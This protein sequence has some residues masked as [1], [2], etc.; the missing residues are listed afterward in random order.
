MKV[1]PTPSDL[2]HYREMEPR[3]DGRLIILAMDQKGKL[4]K[5]KND[6]LIITP[7]EFGMDGELKLVTQGQEIWKLKPTR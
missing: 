2:P 4:L 3:L 6:E 5:R 1:G 7:I